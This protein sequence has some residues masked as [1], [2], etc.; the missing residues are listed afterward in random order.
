M[1]DLENPRF[2]LVGGALC[3][4]FCNTVASRQTGGSFE[5]LA[6]TPALAAFAVQTGLCSKAGAQHMFEAIANRKGVL[7]RAIALREALYRI[8]RSF[9][10]A[11]PIPDDDLEL[12]RSEY[13]HGSAAA[14]LRLSKGDHLVWHWRA[15]APDAAML[16]GHIAH[17]AVELLHSA[18]CERI[19]HC[20]RP[21]CGFL[22]HDTSKAGRRRWCEMELCGNRA[23]QERLQKRRRTG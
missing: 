2:T 23:K 10:G 15:D 20:P 6:D 22:F 14:T 1:I 12:L 4:D 13:L 3:L 11:L 18:R 21:D 16:F 19:K 17:S 7:K 9:G 8:M 5:R